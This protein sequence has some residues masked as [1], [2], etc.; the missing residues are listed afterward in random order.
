MQ[1]ALKKLKSRRGASLLYALLLFFVASMVSVLILT[2]ALTTARRLHDDREQEQNY[3]LLSSAARL[4]KQ[5]LK[6]SCAY[7]MTETVTTESYFFGISTGV[8]QKPPT[9]EYLSDGPLG[10]A[11][12]DAVEKLAGGAE[13]VEG[14]IAVWDDGG[15]AAAKK[16]VLAFEMRRKSDASS[17]DDY[18]LTGTLTLEGSSQTIFFS[19][20]RD[21]ITGPVMEPD[22]PHVYDETTLGIGDVTTIERKRTTI[23]WSNV[24]LSTNETEGAGEGTP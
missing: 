12:A 19:A 10:D 22:Y 2:A 11:L 8:E 4:L 3:L 14:E 9:Y 7:I 6:D 13:Q 17:G 23:K 24:S 20:Y 18:P 15:G 16:A 1:R 21:N 5:E